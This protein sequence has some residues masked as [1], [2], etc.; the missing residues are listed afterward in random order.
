M[1]CGG[2]TLEDFKKDGAEEID[3]ALRTDP[4]PEAIG[5]F[6][7]H[8]GRSAAQGGA[9]GD[10]QGGRAGG[11]GGGQ[12]PVHEHHFAVFPQHDVLRLQVAVNDAA[13]MGKGDGIADPQQD[14]QVFLEGLVPDGVRPRPALEFLHG[15]EQMAGLIHAQVVNGNDVGMIQL[16]GDEGFG[17]EQRLP[18]LVVGL[19][20]PHHFEGDGTGDGGLAGLVDQAHAALS[21][22]AEQLEVAFGIR[23]IGRAHPAELD[24]G[25]RRRFGWNIMRANGLGGHLFRQQQGFV[26]QRCHGLLQQTGG[27]KPFRRIRRQDAL[28]FETFSFGC[29]VRLSCGERV[30]VPFTQYR[31][32]KA[33]RLQV[34]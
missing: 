9:F 27:A 19:R 22:H 20:G 17:Q 30:F 18:V 7:G 29:H 25:L 26:R 13:A 8:V 4:V 3:V 11:D 23:G 12:A 24:S 31:R 5:H 6:G 1:R 34:Q 14:V 16:P 15:I 10:A 32:K 2:G 21:Q 28:A 33:P